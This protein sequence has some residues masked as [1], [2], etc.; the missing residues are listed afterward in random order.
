[1]L[2]GLVIEN[3]RGIAHAD[4]RQLG[5]L[6]VLVGANGSGKST[7]LEA[8]FLAGSPFAADAAGQIV[9]R[10]SQTPNGARWL[11]RGGRMTSYARAAA[12][13]DDGTTQER[14]VHWDP[15]LR[16]SDLIERLNGLHASGPFSAFRIYLGAPTEGEEQTVECVVGFGANNE[17]AVLYGP[18]LPPRHFV[19]FVD[20]RAGEALHDVFS[21]AVQAGRRDALVDAARDV[22]RGLVG[23]EILT[24]QG[25]PRLYLRYANDAVPATLAGDGV[26]T[27]LRTTFELASV[28]NTT[29]LLE[30]PEVHQHPR[31]IRA[32]A[33]AIAEAVRRGT[34]VMLTTHSLELIDMLLAEHTDAELADPAHFQVRRVSLSNGQLRCTTV[35]AGEAAAARTELVEDLR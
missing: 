25:E 3:L 24:D 22:I 17:F 20:P 32:S 26:I 34:Q 31:A 30:E 8:A 15:S 4:L 19:R 35:A 6:V 13:W 18:L 9:A 23:V 14:R 27:L 2:S 28:E 33:K 11:V 16:V 10:R 29:V 21:R 1:V 7:V 5:R 12:R